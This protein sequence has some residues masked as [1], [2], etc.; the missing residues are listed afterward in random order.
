MQALRSWLEFLKRQRREPEG[1]ATFRIWVGINVAVALLATASQ[2]QWPT[3]FY[4]CLGL[5]WFGMFLSHRL[6]GRNNWEIK[7]A[8]SVLMVVALGNFF[9]G[10]A[11]SYYDPREPLA[12][13]LMWLQALHSCDLPS[14]KDLSY[15][16]LSALILMSVAAVL[17]IDLRFAAYLVAYYITVVPALRWNHRS[18]VLERTGWKPVEQAGSGARAAWSGAL[19]MALSILAL[20]GVVV[21][22]MPRLEGFRIRA[23]PVSWERRLQVSAIS[24]G[25]VRNPYYPQQL[26]KEQMRRERTFNPE[27]YSGFNNIVDLQTRGRLVHERVFQV[28]TNVP[29]YFRGLAFDTYDGRFWTQSNQDLR[30]RTITNPPFTFFPLTNN[31]VD[32]V[33]IF[34]IDR[35][36]AN[37]VLFA[38]QAYQVYFP[39]QLL[40]VDANGAMR[41]PFVLEKEMVYSVV[42]RQSRTLPETLRRLPS[43]DPELRRLAAY[44]ALPENVPP[45]LR[46][47]ARE[48]T[49]GKRS[50]Y[51]QALAI[52]SYLQNNFQYTLEVDRYP[53]GADVA[54]HFLFEAKEG[55]CEQFATAMAVLCRLQGIPARYC[56]GYLPGR[57]NPFTGFR[58]VYGDDAHA[59]VEVYLPGHGWMTFDP[60]PGGT[61][62][63][64][65][66]PDA[67]PE[68]RWLGLAIARYLSDQLGIS[69]SSLAW[70]LYGVGGVFLAL[71]ARK[72][73]ARTRSDMD[74]VALCLQQA[75]GLPG[76]DHP[77]GCSPREFARLY[78][79]PSLQ[80]LVALHE[81]VAYRGALSDKQ[82]QAQARLLLS[83]LRR[84]IKQAARKS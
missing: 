50:F 81:Q 42:S 3:F 36:M 47:L 64:E 46:K 28:R 10:L 74:P 69:W 82:Q 66:Q 72:A 60:T 68:Q 78:P 19:R 22:L 55:Y 77:G 83:E 17:S 29:V 4:P 57:Y 27:G 53:E 25:E 49:Q 41:A 8:L 39:S 13:L 5:T 71:A 44:R 45:R 51:E 32:I 84:E 9:V 76:L 26:T 58:E 40:Y 14:R 37:L 33:Q 35:P 20:G 24:K 18:L 1:S 15:S 21:A 12:E 62:T 30:T 80:A 16:L 31:A 38:P 48:I 7:A 67:A 34:Y 23:L 79:Y 6:R 61:A 56:T 43:K 54:E 59:W 75:F 52:S 63:P 65:I 2:L 73:L 11:N 70:V